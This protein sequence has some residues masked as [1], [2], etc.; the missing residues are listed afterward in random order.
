MAFTVTGQLDL[1]FD[2][3][4][5]GMA[6]KPPSQQE[7]P[8]PEIDPEKWAAFEATL[9]RALKTPPT[10]HKSAGKKGDARK[11]RAPRKAVK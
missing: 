6:K 4:C 3:G 7:K 8:E 2:R 10:L 11:K 5:G 1:M 9:K